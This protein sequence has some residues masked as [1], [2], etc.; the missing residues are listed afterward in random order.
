M[1]SWVSSVLKK[2]PTTPPCQGSSILS[3]RC[4]LHED[5]RAPCAGGGD[6]SVLQA[7]R[8]VVPSLFGGLPPRHV[9]QRGLV[10]R[11]LVIEKTHAFAK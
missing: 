9:A 3:D 11:A 5:C 7:T 8:L 10:G 4:A 1:R 2:H 6:A